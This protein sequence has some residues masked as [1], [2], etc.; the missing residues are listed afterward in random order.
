MMRAPLPIW[1]ELFRLSGS[2]RADEQLDP[3]VMDLEDVACGRDDRRG[4][5]LA[6]ADLD[7]MALNVEDLARV[8][9]EGLARIAVD[10][11]RAT[12]ELNRLPGQ[13]RGFRFR[14]LGR[15]SPIGI[16]A[17]GHG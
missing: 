4:A 9:A 2:G 16:R 11:A 14:Y 7:R 10:H 15:R 13:S 1:R 6:P 17:I 12:C 8:G 5:D 3:L